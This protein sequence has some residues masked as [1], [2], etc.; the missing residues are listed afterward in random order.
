MSEQLDLF[1][2]PEPKDDDQGPCISHPPGTCGS[3]AN[4]RL[5]APEAPACH[6]CTAGVEDERQPMVTGCASWV[7][8]KTLPLPKVKKWEES[9]E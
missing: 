2:L 3:C 4:W 7:D 9:G 8:W 6:H 5:G 1:A